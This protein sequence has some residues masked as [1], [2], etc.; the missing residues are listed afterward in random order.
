MPKCE[1]CPHE[2]EIVNGTEAI[3]K[4]RKLNE[5]GEIVPSFYGQLSVASVEPIEKKPFYHYRPGTKVLSIGSWGCN[6]KCTYCE[7]FFI[8]QEF[9]TPD[10]KSYSPVEI[11]RMAI[12]NECQ[13]VCMS[14]NEPSI[15]YEYLMKLAKC[16]RES[17]LYFAVKTNGYVNYIH[18]GSLCEAVDAVNIDWKPENVAGVPK[19]TDHIRT[20]IKLA[21]E[22]NYG[23]HVEIS[24]PIISEDPVVY[25][26]IAAYFKP[27]I[28]NRVPI[29]LLPVTPCHKNF[30]P[31]PRDF[32]VKFIRDFVFRD[33]FYVYADLPDYPQMSD[34]LCPQ[35]HNVL[36]E[37]R[38]F[39]SLIM[40]TEKD[41]GCCSSSRQSMT[42]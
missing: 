9:D 12:E 7:N 32:Y 18:W 20:C 23:V 33:S 40:P 21:I 16:T 17:G 15:Q 14:F 31:R 10:V 13:G 19:Y 6:L 29:H 37:R 34:T 11:V 41:K 35:C 38:A 22:E 36:V 26:H 28:K 42:L 2:C 25:E 24:V 1:I 3:C 30:E 4:G 8:S 5:K 39:S 27:T